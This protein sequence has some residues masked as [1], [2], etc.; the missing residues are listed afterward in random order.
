MHSMQ[1]L[2]IIHV[3][4]QGVTHSFNAFIR[5][6]SLLTI[7]YIHSHSH[8]LI[9]IILIHIGCCTEYWYPSVSQQSIL[10]LNRRKLP[11]PE[12]RMCRIE[13]KDTNPPPR[14]LIIIISSLLIRHHPVRPFTM[15]HQFVQIRRDS[16]HSFKIT[17]NSLPP[18]FLDQCRRYKFSLHIFGQSIHCHFL[19]IRHHKL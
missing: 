11:F 9:L 13:L 10:F 2:V 19:M 4:N 18:L 3:I 14:H 1:I 5:Y 17:Q 12:Y 7:G 8:I 16:I 15:Y 6:N